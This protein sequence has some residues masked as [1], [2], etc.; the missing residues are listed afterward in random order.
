MSTQISP[1]VRSWVSGAPQPLTALN[2]CSNRQSMSRL[3]PEDFF[4]ER[5]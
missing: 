1:V 2:L 4:Q 3:A 5:R